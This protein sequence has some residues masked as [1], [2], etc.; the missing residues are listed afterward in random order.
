MTS[1]LFRAS[2]TTR[3]C[4]FVLRAALLI[5]LVLALNLICLA[6]TETIPPASTTT[7]S[8]KPL[9]SDERDELLKLIRSLQQRIEK[10]EA[11]QAASAQ[12]TPQL[13]PP[14]EP[15]TEGK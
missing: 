15:I 14:K 7:S 4:S 5:E 12:E 11:A 8:D 13:A 6:Q 2:P 1:I 9:T 3:R 10:L